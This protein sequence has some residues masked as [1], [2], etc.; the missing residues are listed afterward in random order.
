MFY[1]SLFPNWQGF[2]WLF[3]MSLPCFLDTE[4]NSHDMAKQEK[5]SG[6][7][8]GCPLMDVQEKGVFPETAK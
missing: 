3:S 1:P 2:L 8:L 5:S 6:M 7:D 4:A